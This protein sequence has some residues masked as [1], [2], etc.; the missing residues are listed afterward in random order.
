MKNLILEIER[1][2]LIHKRCPA[3]EIFCK[4]CREIKDFVK[5]KDVASIFCVEEE[6]LSEF[7]KSNLRHY[8]EAESGEMFICV[9]SLLSSINAGCKKINK[10]KILQE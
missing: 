9:S 3:E 2:Q 7:V 8:T 4:E 6:K 10:L 1:V 5:L